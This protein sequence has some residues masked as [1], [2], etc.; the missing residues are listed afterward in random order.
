MQNYGLFNNYDYQETKYQEFGVV[1]VL[2]VRSHP[3]LSVQVDL[4]HE[5]QAYRDEQPHIQIRQQQNRV[6]HEKTAV[7]YHVEPAEHRP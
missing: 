3:Q 7:T 1:W 5:Y 4:W 2:Q 6:Q